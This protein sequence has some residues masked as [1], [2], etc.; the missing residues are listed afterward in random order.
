MTKIDRNPVMELIYAI[1][2]AGHAEMHLLELMAINPDEAFMFTESLDKAR[3][4]RVSLMEQL[5]YN[6]T[7]VNPLWCVFKH[8]ILLLTHLMEEYEKSKSTLI[9]KASQDTM[10]LIDDL[11]SMPEV[12]LKHCARCEKDKE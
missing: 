8:L 10:L 2:N 5:S 1:S 4:I 9:L 7:M 11:L 3:S 6:F 12:E